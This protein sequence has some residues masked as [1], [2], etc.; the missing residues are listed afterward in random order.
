MSNSRCGAGSLSRLAIGLHGGTPT[1]MDFVEWKPVKM[2]KALSDGGDKAIRGTLDHIDT[3]VTEGL[4][5]VEFR[6]MMWMTSAK[7]DV[8]LPCLGFTEVSDVFTLGDSLP[9]SK[10]I[11]GPAGTKEHVFDNVV[12]TDFVVSGQ[13]GSDPIMID[14]GWMGTTW[15]EQSNATFFTSQSSPAMT[16]GYIYAFPN[17]TSG[18]TASL[19]LLGQTVYYPQF[20]LAVDYGIIREFNNSVTATNLC[21]TDHKI[22]FATSA[23]YSSCDGNEALID[24]PLAGT[25]T[26]ASLTLNFQR[27]VGVQNHQTQFVIANAKAIARPPVI[28]KNDFNR[29]P[30]QMMGYA[31]GS[32]AALVVTNKVNE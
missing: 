9:Y 7:M 14:I 10:I 32:T 24:T 12:P 4:T 19:N 25:T 3:N 31:S 22:T 20:K 2:L 18:G 6:T 15:A 28:V 21:P 1:R 17:P 29:L 11:L 27:T 5:Y 26:G 23:L 16:E 8:L 30:I 13:K